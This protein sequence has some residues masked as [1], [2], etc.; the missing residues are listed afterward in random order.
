MNSLRHG[1]TGSD[2]GLLLDLTIFCVIVIPL[3]LIVLLIW[4]ATRDE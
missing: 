3:I 4:E 1:A 2:F